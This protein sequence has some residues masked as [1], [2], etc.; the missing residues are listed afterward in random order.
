MRILFVQPWQT[1]AFGGELNFIEPL[2]LEM[3][4]ACLP[5]HEVR[6]AHLVDSDE[7]RS[8]VEDFHPDLAGVSCTFTVDVRRA[9]EAAAVLKAIDRPPLVLIGGHHASLRPADF[10]VESVDVVVVGEAELTVPE[11]VACL[12]EKADLVR[13][14]GLV[15]NRAD[16]QVR[17]GRRELIADLDSLPFPARHLTDEY[18]HRYH[19]GFERGVAGVQTARGCPFHCSF[20]SVWRYYRGKCRTMSPPRVVAEIERL[21]ERYVFLLDDN[22]LLN[23]PRA[24]EIGR[25]L[26][27]RGVE[28][29]YFMQARSDTVVEHPEVVEQ[30]SEIG[31]QTVYMGFEKIRQEEMDR[32]NKANQVKN[33][34]RAVEIL[35]NNG[36]WVSGSFIIGPDY[37]AEDFQALA[38]FLQSCPVDSPTFPV[39]TPLPGTDLFDEMRDE[40]ITADW[41]LFDLYHTVLET[42]LPLDEFYQQLSSLYRLAY[43]TSRVI[44][45]ALGAVSDVVSGRRGLSDIRRM[46]TVGK[47]MTDPARYLAGHLPHGECQ[48]VWEASLS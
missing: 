9:L 36:I 20:C 19:L 45:T 16:G 42:K 35:H 34:A 1:A 6:I 4:G 26:K 2:A 38:A 23:V 46:V 39:L 7:L 32:L 10:F 47:E 3:L 15:L 44:K 24:K 17:T 28:K 29:R 31:L 13:V 30:W 18:R 33:N 48:E 5:G 41:E 37:G 25:L 8:V 11:L 22:F 21:E 43:P 27:N 14:R 40:L 12:E